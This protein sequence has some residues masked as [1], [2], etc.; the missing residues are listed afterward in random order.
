M[1]MTT[2]MSLF[3]HYEVD[4]D[5][6]ISD[7]NEIRYNVVNSKGKVLR[8]SVVRSVAVRYIESLNEDVQKNVKLVPV[9]E[10]GE[11]ILFG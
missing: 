2:L 4:M 1:N 10:T 9:L 6:I 8:S 3:I 5:N 11:Q 7:N